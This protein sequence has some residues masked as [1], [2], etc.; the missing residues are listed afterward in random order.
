MPPYYVPGG[1]GWVKNGPV[2]RTEEAFLHRY[3]NLHAG[4]ACNSGG[5]KVPRNFKNAGDKNGTGSRTMSDI[6]AR[7]YKFPP[8]VKKFFFTCGEAD[9]S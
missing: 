6:V 3:T 7:P 2:I 8:G 4:L 1:W 5:E 9:R